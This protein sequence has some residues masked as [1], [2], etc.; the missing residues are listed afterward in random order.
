MWRP[1][2]A[3]HAAGG[4]R[5]HDADRSV[6]ARFPDRWRQAGFCFRAAEQSRRCRDV[7]RPRRAGGAAGRMRTRTGSPAGESGAESAHPLYRRRRRDY[8]RTLLRE[9]AAVPPANSRRTRRSRPAGP[10]GSSWSIARCHTRSIGWISNP[11]QPAAA[12]SNLPDG[13]RIR[14]QQGDKTIEQWIPSGW[15]IG[16]PTSPAA[17][18]GGVR[19]AAASNAD[20]ARVARL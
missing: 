19:L 7:A 13:V 14:V 3:G 5:V 18:P 6:L 9:K 12:A 8:L 1:I 15:Q 17:D 10:I 11:T 16:V 4:Q 20:R 2:S